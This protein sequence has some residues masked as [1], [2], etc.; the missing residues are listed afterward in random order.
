MTGCRQL[1]RQLETRQGLGGAEV[2]QV[3]AFIFS[4]PGRAHYQL[5]QYDRAN[6]AAFL[7]RGEKKNQQGKEA[8]AL[9]VGNCKSLLLPTSSKCY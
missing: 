9:A 2:R 7:F 4:T 6:A 1:Y 3:V 5:L 8:P